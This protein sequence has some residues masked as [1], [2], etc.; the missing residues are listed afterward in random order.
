MFMSKERVL[1][2][3]VAMA[4]L[5]AIIKKRE[6]TRVEQLVEISSKILSKLIE[7]YNILP[8]EINIESC[9]KRYSRKNSAV[10]C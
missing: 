4:T 10:K 2:D 1:E 6:E 5:E 7:R 8:H 3:F 9:R